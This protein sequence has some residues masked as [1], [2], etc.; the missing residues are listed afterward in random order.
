MEGIYLNRGIHIIA[1]DPVEENIEQCNNIL[2]QIAEDGSIPRNIR[3]GAEEIVGALVGQDKALDLRYAAAISRLDD[4]ANDPNM[5]LHGR[6]LVWNAIRL[7]E[8]L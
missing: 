3:R 1:R 4:F 7:L 2:K 5:P 8:S 6:T